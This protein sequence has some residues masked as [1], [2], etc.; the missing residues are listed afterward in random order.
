MKQFF[1]I[2]TLIVATFFVATQT[3]AQNQQTV[4]TPTTV[5]NIPP[6]PAGLP[7]VLPEGITWETWL[8]QKTSSLSWVAKTYENHKR[9]GRFMGEF[10]AI[11]ATYGLLEGMNEGIGND[12]LTEI[13][14]AGEYTSGDR[15]MAALGL[16]Q[17]LLHEFLRNTTLRDQTFG[18]VMKEY[19]KEAKGLDADA[20]KAVLEAAEYAVQYLHSFNEKAEVAHLAQENQKI[21]YDGFYETPTPRFTCAGPD[22]K[23][24]PYRKVGCWLFRRIHDDHVPSEM[25][26]SYAT[27][28]RDEIR[29]AMSTQDA[30]K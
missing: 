23:L 14:S 28:A 2:I 18:W 21:D 25:L 20:Q 5:I 22:G 24:S 1:A 16:R 4:E 6:A 27:K 10:K 30:T 7:A 26:L 19:V 12:K 8:G 11:M 15:R 9:F 29:K 17:Y 3:N 13:F